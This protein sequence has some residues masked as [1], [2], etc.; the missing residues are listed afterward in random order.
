MD[1]TILEKADDVIE[2]VLVITDAFTKWTRTIPIR[3]Q[4]AKTVAKILVKEW[5][6]QYGVPKRLHSDQGRNF[7]SKLIQQLWSIVMEE[8]GVEVTSAIEVE[9]K[10]VLIMV[11]GNY[12]G[13]GGPHPTEAQPNQVGAENHEQT[14]L[15]YHLG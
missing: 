5:F 12:R 9:V 10:Q 13:R 8:V 14:S 1:F 3:D 2:N 15:N 4:T 6:H 11:M 7:E